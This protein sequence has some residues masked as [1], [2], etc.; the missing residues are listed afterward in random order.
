MRADK[1]FLAPYWWT[2][3][4]RHLLYDRGWKKA[5]RSPIPTLCIGNLAVGGTGK[6]P[7][8][9]LLLKLL[10][11]SLP[12]TAGNETQDAFCEGS[13]VTPN[14]IG[15]PVAV[16]SKGY[17]R[18]SKGFLY[19]ETDGTPARFG[20]EP[21]Q[22]KRKFPDVPVAVCSDRIEGCR[23][24]AGDG[25]S[26]ILLDDAFQFRALKADCNIVL[27]E[28]ER[29][30][31]QDRLL[32]LGRLR[33]LSSRI[34]AADIVIASKCPDDLTDEERQA[35]IKTLGLKNAYDASA[36]GVA[37]AYE[38]ASACDATS[39]SGGRHSRPDRESPIPVFFTT[40][41]YADP[42]AVFPEGDRHYLYSGK[43]IVVT[44]I[45]NDRP[46]LAH[47]G[48]KYRLASHLR[49]PDHHDFNSADLARIEAAAASTPEA[50]LLTTEKD[51]QRLLPLC[52]KLSDDLRRRLFYLPIETRFLNPDDEDAFLKAQ[53]RVLLKSL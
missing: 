1:I 10:R 25:A 40:L 35:W 41:R 15:G 47:L 7:F 19:V 30:L 27:V 50:L 4:L 52:E 23:K 22:I 37:S 28:Y 38:V 29:P 13:G 43:M 14:P 39:Q 3:K 24:L 51:A 9:E 32:P 53:N 26:R 45:A 34:A 6:T 8:T 36:Y 42:E 31:S 48:E 5:Q 49:F 12:G 20:D 16:L 46:M 33:D 44:G 2:L 21:L 17:G 18:K 11:N